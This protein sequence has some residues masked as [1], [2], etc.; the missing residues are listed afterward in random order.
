M[1]RPTRSTP[2]RNPWAL[3]GALTTFGFLNHVDTQSQRLT[4]IYT[5]MSDKHLETLHISKQSLVR[6]LMVVLRLFE[7]E[8]HV[9]HSS[10]VLP[11]VNAHCVW[12]R[13]SVVFVL[14]VTNT[15]M[16]LWT[17]NWQFI[18]SQATWYN[19]AC[20]YYALNEVFFYYRQTLGSCGARTKASP[21]QE[22]IRQRRF[23]Q[24]SSQSVADTGYR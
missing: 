2:F 18:C 19:D 4:I 17:L 15:Q 23:L 21:T 8:A 1:L 10:N 14:Q 7:L 20:K 13:L 11:D 16:P 5:L 9:K 3:S 22:S 24:Q 12:W 6:S